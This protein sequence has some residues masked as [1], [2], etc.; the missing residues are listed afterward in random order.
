MKFPGILLMMVCCAGCGMYAACGI[1]NQVRTYQNLLLLL[2][3]CLTYMQYQ[4]LN[5]E[6]LF[7][8][9][10]G[11]AVYQNL[12]FVR[13]LNPVPGLP[14]ETLWNQAL[15]ESHLPE[16]ARRILLLLGSELGKSDLQGQTA[17]LTL[18]RAQMCTALEACQAV[19]AQKCRL[20]QSLGW[21]GGAVCAVMFL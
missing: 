8:I 11:K 1:R 2:E 12:D 9:L 4:H 7:G 14:P 18:C 17:V 15:E 10:S 16:E 3:D 6:E 20:Y 5:L 21:L 19:S 13:K